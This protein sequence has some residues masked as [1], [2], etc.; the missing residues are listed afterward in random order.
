MVSWVEGL[1]PRNAGTVFLNV[2]DPNA[3]PREE[4]RAQSHTGHWQLGQPSITLS[5][6]ANTIEA[7]QADHVRRVVIDPELRAERRV[8]ALEYIP[9]DPRVVRAAFFTVQETGQ[10]LGSW[11][12]WYGYALLPTAVSYRLSPGSHIVAE[13]HYRGAKD[14]VVDRGTLGLF[15]SDP[16]A[17]STVSDL[18]LETKGD[19]AAGATAQRFRAQTRLTTSI[20]A[21]AL[22]PELLP[23]LQ[24]IEV[25]ARRADGGTSV[26]LF[27]RDPQ[28]DW[29]TPY[30]F[31]EPV[32]LA[33]GTDLSV[34][35]YYANPSSAPMRGGVRLTISRY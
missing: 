9:G 8:R 31:K 16:P 22:R 10:W 25:S 35:A 20:S 26:L 33:A 15:Y 32:R 21:L 24:S 6:P 28:L 5:L 11:T 30:I 13:V 3:R 29:P 12:P 34:T 17:T 23:G 14:P 7:G 27:A 1:G 18:V 19:V 2:L 4:V